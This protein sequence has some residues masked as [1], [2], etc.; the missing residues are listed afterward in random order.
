VL[1]TEFTGV[2]ISGE[3]PALGG[4]HPLSAIL[5]TMP[6]LTEVPTEPEQV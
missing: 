4:H 1:S 2:T 6:T 5:G 3:A